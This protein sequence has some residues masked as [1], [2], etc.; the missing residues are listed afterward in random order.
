[1]IIV[2]ALFLSAVISVLVRGEI[3]CMYSEP[4]PSP[5]L[6]PSPPPTFLNLLFSPPLHYV[7]NRIVGLSL[8]LL[9]ACSQ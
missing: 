5:P 1:M 2:V 9:L 6:F 3:I 8:S 7:I 4:V